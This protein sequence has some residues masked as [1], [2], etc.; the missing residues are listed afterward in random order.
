MAKK[1]K[2]KKKKMSPEEK[3]KQRIERKFYRDFRS[4]M[5]E[6]GL[7][8]VRA[9]GLEI[10]FEG[11]TG[12]LDDIFVYENVL[13]LVE[14]TLGKPDSAHV[15][16]K[17]PLFDKI[18][19]N[20]AGFVDFAKETYP[21][22]PVHLKS[23]YDSDHYQIAI[24]YVPLHEAAQETMDACPNIF[25][26]QG[27]LK[28]YFLALGKT[29]QQSARV[30]F[31]SYLKLDWS[32]IGPATVG[33]SSKTLNYTGQVL[34]TAMSSFP[35]G[36]RVVSFYADPESL[37]AGAYVLRRDGW[38]DSSH[39]YQRVLVSGKIKKMR[40]YL[41]DEGR[42]F[43]NNVIVTLP[44]GTALNALEMKAT[45]VPEQDLN[46]ARPVTVA[47]P[48]G[49]SVIGI[50]DGQHRVFCYH[51]GN[52]A[53]EESIA[54][55]RRRQHLLVTG[56]IYPPGLKEKTRLE[57]EA[58]LFLEIN[59]TQTR[60]RPA[61]R[62]DI[63]TIV[64]PFSGIAVARRVI[65]RLAKQGPYAGLF[66][67]AYFDSPAKIKTSSIVSY[68][69][70]PIVKFDGGDSLFSAWK[71]PEKD[72]LKEREKKQKKGAG[73]ELDLELLDEY[74]DFCVQSLNDFFLVCKLS[75][76]TSGWDVEAQNPSPLLR[77]TSIN[78][79]IACLRRIIEHKLPLSQQAHKK[80]LSD[81]SSFKFGTYKSSHWDSLGAAL[82]EKHYDVS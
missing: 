82:F 20:K 45:N 30:E 41:V 59:D 76:G 11:R 66:Q 35:T 2:S 29:I 19:A 49:Y 79:Q 53:F 36:Y 75:Y 24:I 34:P 57:F 28:K 43:V 21:A 72:R 81:I 56:I 64:R 27:G 78:G 37:I 51:E 33:A 55:L 70:R 6:L 60:A 25:F 42:V 17:K 46:K 3:A 31:F 69:L 23:L 74:V 38:R 12:E 62:Q 50:I 9:D 10:K 47:I 77:P 48:V 1:A 16:K 7:T 54:K 58:R 8:H 67:L 68:G 71:H 63:E 52:D 40:R 15:L 18:L 26:L 80:R 39:L 5:R 61:L 13:V 4:L 14:Y 65:A 32:D 73:Y 44:A 22:L